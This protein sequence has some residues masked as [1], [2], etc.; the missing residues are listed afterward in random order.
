M[1]VLTA[2][3]R[4]QEKQSRMPGWKRSLLRASRLSAKRRSRNSGKQLGFVS[5][6]PLCSVSPTKRAAKARKKNRPRKQRINLCRA[7][8]SFWS[9]LKPG[10][11]G[12]RFPVISA[13]GIKR[14]QILRDDWRK[15][16]II[17]FFAG[18]LCIAKLSKSWNLRTLNDGR[19]FG[20]RIERCPGAGLILL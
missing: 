3:A 9:A 4:C 17:L 7:I 18:T 10:R 20:G 12:N 13:P 19:L 16:S 15:R 11:R 1:Q 5:Q 2:Y 14:A 6:S 8:S